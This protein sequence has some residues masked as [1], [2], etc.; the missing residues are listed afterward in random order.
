MINNLFPT[1]VYYTSIDE[2]ILKT[3]Q[4]DIKKYIKDND[5]LFKTNQWKCNTETN[6]FCDE[7][8]KF[9][10]TYLKDLIIKN[11][12]HYMVE[13]NFKPRA[14]LVDDCW[15]TIGGDGGYQ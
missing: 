2:E 12:S 4:K 1:P 14:F 15:I 10:P 9:F 11:T 7:S 5:D 13:C 8:R 6:I 3:L